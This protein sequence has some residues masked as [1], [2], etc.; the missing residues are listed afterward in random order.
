MT[1]YEDGYECPIHG[2]VKAKIS[3]NNKENDVVAYCSVC[4]AILQRVIPVSFSKAAHLGLGGLGQQ[5][6]RYESNPIAPASEEAGA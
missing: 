6:R 5:N 1:V 4:G 2:E 3:W